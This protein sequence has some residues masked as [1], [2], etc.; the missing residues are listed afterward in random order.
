MVFFGLL[1]SYH[2]TICFPASKCHVLV[3][4][5][6]L[7]ILVG[8]CLKQ[9]LFTVVSVGFGE[10]AKLNVYVQSVIIFRASIFTKAVNRL[11]IAYCESYRRNKHGAKT[12]TRQEDS[13][14]GNTVVSLKYALCSCVEK[15]RTGTCMEPKMVRKPLWRTGERGSGLESDGCRAGRTETGCNL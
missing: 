13:D 6:I 10:G 14:L 15:D 4:T 7:L 12:I 1:C 3:P 9:N 2:P 8:L 5:L 11:I